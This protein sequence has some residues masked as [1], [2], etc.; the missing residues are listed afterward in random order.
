MTE[1]TPAQLAAADAIDRQ[2]NAL[3]AERDEARALAEEACRRYNDLLAHRTVTCIYCGH[4]FNDGTP[5]SQD[6]RL[7]QHTR[8]CEKHPL[9]AAEAERDALREKC[10]RY[11]RALNKIAQW[12]DGPTVNAG[13]DEPGSAEEAREALAP[14]KDDPPVLADSRLESKRLRERLG[15]AIESSVKRDQSVLLMQQMLLNHHLR[16]VRLAMELDKEAD[17]LLTLARKE[18]P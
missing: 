8:T 3:R 4:A 10:E 6:E 17:R 7:L 11:E 15:Y 9:R 1:I 2:R 5:T 14:P 16:D 13:F 18:H 12:H